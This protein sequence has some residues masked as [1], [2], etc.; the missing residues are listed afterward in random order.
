MDA[1]QT[2]LLFR[3]IGKDGCAGNRLTLP[4]YSASDERKE[5]A[6]GSAGFG[7]CC[8]WAAHDAGFAGLLMKRAK[9]KQE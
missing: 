7:C 8:I 6:H 9:N 4:R 3:S 1:S 5:R 2:M